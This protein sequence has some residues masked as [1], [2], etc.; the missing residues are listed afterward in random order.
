MGTQY[1]RAYGMQ[2]NSATG[3]KAIAKKKKKDY[4]NKKKGYKSQ[5][6]SIMVHFKGQN[7]AQ[8]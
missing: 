4:I 1:T 2:Y 7:E 6:Y 5:I 8:S 3:N